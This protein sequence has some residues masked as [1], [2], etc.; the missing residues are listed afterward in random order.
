M[1]KRDTTLHSIKTLYTVYDMSFDVNFLSNNVKTF[2]SV[3]HGI[4]EDVGQED[5]QHSSEKMIM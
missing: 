3:D 1:T 5:P 4:P 2:L